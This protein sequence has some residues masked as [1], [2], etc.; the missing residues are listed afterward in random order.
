MF[1]SIPEL[2]RGMDHRFENV[3]LNPDFTKD[4][5]YSALRQAVGRVGRP[6]NNL[7][8]VIID[9][10][11]AIRK[12]L[13]PESSSREISLFKQALITFVNRVERKVE[14]TIKVEKF[15]IF[16]PK[17]PEPEPE[18]EIVDSWEDL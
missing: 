16:K 6:G 18:P 2:I 3:M 11:E 9:D 5:S 8:S 14:P 12:L 4:A 15:K 13:D 1:L 7:G 17:Q 10:F